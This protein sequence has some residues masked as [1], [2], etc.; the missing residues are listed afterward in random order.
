MAPLF[1]RLENFPAE[2]AL[3]FSK[4]VVSIY[5]FLGSGDTIVIII[6]KGHNLELHGAYGLVEWRRETSNTQ[7]NEYKAY[8]MVIHTR[9]NRKAR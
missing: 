1:D 6:K 5:T 7:T 8:Q 2:P 9:E 3:P 4:D